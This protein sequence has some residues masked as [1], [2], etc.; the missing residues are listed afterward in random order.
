L[1]TELES[2]IYMENFALWALIGTCLLHWATV[3]VLI[4]RV[5]VTEK[6]VA[7]NLLGLAVGLLGIQQSYGVYLQ[8]IE[9]SPPVLNLFQEV[10][11]LLVAGLLFGGVLLLAPILN[12]V[13]RNKELLAVIDERNVI[14]H[15]F[16]DRIARALRQI[17]I[18]MEV[19]KPTTYIIEQTANLS[20]LLQMFLEDLKA[21]VLLGNR[22]DIALRTLVDELSKEGSFPISVQVNASLEEHISSEQ[23]VELLHI[24]REAIQNC[25]KHSQAKKGRVSVSHVKSQLV[26]EVSDNGK[27]FE[28]DLVGAQGHGLGNMV[29]RAKEIGARLKIHSQP[30]KGTTVLIE[31]PLNEASSSPNYSVGTSKTSMKEAHKVPVG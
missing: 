18:A 12:I 20:R 11:G 16:H 6:P 19:G 22:F 30:N 2:S 4:Q 26:F 28:V 23:G 31:L 7:W 14:F 8:Y 29:L 10:S 24:L 13:Q 21:G 1:F 17:Q 5:K 9:P 25:V 15:Q 3:W 27:G